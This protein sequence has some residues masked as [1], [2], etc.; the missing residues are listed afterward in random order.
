VLSYASSALL[1]ALLVPSAVF[2]S[3]DAIDRVTC[4]VGAIACVCV[5]ALLAWA[6][7]QLA[8]GTLLPSRDDEDRDYR[9]TWWLPIV[10][11]GLGALLALYRGAALLVRGLRRPE[12]NDAVGR[13]RLPLACAHLVL[14]PYLAFAHFM[15][16]AALVES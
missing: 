5:G 9:S 10:L 2:V 4:W 7:L 13:E 11:P 6:S 14:A 3:S 1:G 16:L 12:R 15:V 8:Y